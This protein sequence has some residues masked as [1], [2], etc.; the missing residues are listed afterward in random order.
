MQ[1]QLR[2]NRLTLRDRTYN[3]LTQA[4]DYAAFSNDGFQGAEQDPANYDSLES[5]HNQIH[6]L[7]GNNGHMGVVDYAAFDPVFWMHHVNVRHPSVVT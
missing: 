5:I 6:G 1:A 2:N 3:L 7:T 4:T